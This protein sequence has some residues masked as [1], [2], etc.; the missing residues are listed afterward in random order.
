[1]SPDPKGL[2][3]DLGAGLILRRSSIRDAQALAEFCGFIHS[4]EAD[5]S[6]E[7]IAAWAHDLLTR[8]HPTFASDD[9]TIVEEEATGRIVST[10][11][12]ISQKWTYD[13]IEIGVG[14]PELVGSLPEFRNRGLVRIQFD[15]IHRWSAERG[16]LLQAITGIPYFY[17]KFGYEMAVELDMSRTGFEMNLPKLEDGQSEPFR[18]RRAAESDIAF[19]MEINERA[20]KRYLVYPLRDRAL[21]LYELEG[22]SEKNVTRLEWEII[23]RTEDGERVGFLGR[24]WF[25]W[26][27]TTVAMMYELKGGASWLEVTPSVARRLW[28]LSR[29]FSAQDGRP[30]S[31]FTFFLGERHPAYEVMRDN[32][33]RLHR[34]YAWYLRVPDLGGFLRPI[35]PV[36]ERR[37]AESLIPGFG[38]ALRLGFYDHGLQLDF[39]KGKLKGIRNWTPSSQDEG[40]V[41]FPNLTFL[42]LLFGYRDLDELAH[43]YPDCLWRTDQARV[44][45]STLF[46]KKPSTILGIA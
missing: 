28:Q 31:S 29:E 25:G 45:A 37:L 11:N 15:E 2:P 4:A 23:E 22:R 12:L 14:R 3:R 16:E 7:R 20:A 46:P 30:R 44:L 5:K 27:T 8:P 13:G 24:P 10:L 19:M 43:A 32:L 6:D 21:W 38:G 39:E 9:F 33:P 35:S 34:P 40:D 26:K 42:Q 17:R 18:F 1:M 36:L 41:A